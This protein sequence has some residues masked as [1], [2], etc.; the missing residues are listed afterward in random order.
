MS[1]AK[2][3]AMRV[4]RQLHA[5]EA[6]VDEALKAAAA[7][8]AMLPDARQQANLSALIGQGALE[9]VIDSVGS[10]GAARG[11]LV[12]AH[13]Q[14][15]ITHE[16]IGLGEAAFGGWVDKPDYASANP[17]LAVVSKAA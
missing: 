7:L 15:T 16:K 5:A 8:V 10:L 2:L 9:Q 4:A 17:G 1:N 14:L 6:A 11:A 3:A 12:K 13:K